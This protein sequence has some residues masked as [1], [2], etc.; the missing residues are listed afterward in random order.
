MPGAF[1]VEAVAE[2]DAL[3][4]YLLD[5]QFEN[6][7]VADSSVTATL[8]QNGKARQLQCRPEDGARSFVCPLSEGSELTAGELMVDASRDGVPGETASYD[9]PL[10]QEEDTGNP[11]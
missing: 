5:M 10:M 6:P 2:N 4:V 1:H 3:R 9:L 8:E 7:Q 11:E